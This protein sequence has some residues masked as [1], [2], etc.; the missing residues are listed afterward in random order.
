MM[1]IFHKSKRDISLRDDWQRR[2]IVLFIT[3]GYHGDNEI[4]KHLECELGGNL[5]HAMAELQSG[6]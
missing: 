2:E 1:R 3:S 4:T 5:G 6:L